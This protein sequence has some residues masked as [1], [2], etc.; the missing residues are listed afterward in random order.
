MIKS[1][2][3]SFSEHDSQCFFISFSFLTFSF[4]TF[5]RKT[6][7]KIPVCRGR[8]EHCGLCSED[9]PSLVHLRCLSLSVKMCDGIEQTF[10]LIFCLISV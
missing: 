3:V 10:L 2:S 5:C 8:L 6:A 7:K 9:C 4:L 1:V